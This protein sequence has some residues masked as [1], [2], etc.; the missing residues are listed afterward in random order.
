MEPKPPMPVFDLFRVLAK[1]AL[2]GNFQKEKA[3]SAE[4]DALRTARKPIENPL[5]QDYA[6]WRRAILYLAAVTMTIH[7]VVSFF[8][9]IEQLDT[10]TSG[11]DMAGMGDMGAITKFVS[12]ALYLR[13]PATAVLI[14]LAARQWTDV[15]ASRRH[16]RIAGIVYFLSAV[17]IAAIPWTSL[18]GEGQAGMPTEARMGMGLIFGLMLFAYVAPV[19]IAVLSGVFRSSMV[20]KTLLPESPAAGWGA[21]IYLPIYLLVIVSLMVVLMQMMGGLMLT[22]GLAS[23]LGGA[24]IYL[25]HAKS[26]V[27][28]CSDAEV[29]GRIV[30]VRSKALLFTAIGIF[31]I[32]AFAWDTMEKMG[33]EEGDI[34]LQI[35]QFGIGVW[36]GILL[37]TVVAADFILA[38]VSANLSLGRS[39]HGTELANSLENKIDALKNVGLTSFATPATT[40]TMRTVDPG[41]PD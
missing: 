8:G 10:D 21:I 15:K 12:S 28:P 25:K 19:P 30:S 5:A 11:L 24:I 18:A 27:K 35:L 4:R 37:M 7:A 14:I 31:L 3:L 38:V 26:I 29:D 16:T 2:V 9:W 20:L 40:G 39:F 36:S 17:A 6:A 32:I 34:M 22:L 13:I 23:L 33:M 1:R 41:N